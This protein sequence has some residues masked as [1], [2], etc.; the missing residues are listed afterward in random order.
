[1][2]ESKLCWRSHMKNNGD[3]GRLDTRSSQQAP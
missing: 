3:E 2:L 1:V